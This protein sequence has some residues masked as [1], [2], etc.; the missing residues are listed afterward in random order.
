MGQEYEIRA[1]APATFMLMGEHAVLHGHPALTCAAD[2]RIQVRLT[3]HGAPMLRVHSSIAEYEANLD[4]LGDHPK[5]RFV[6]QAVRAMRDRLPS[7]FSLDITSDF[8]DQVGLGSSA[9]VTV[10]TAAALRFW[11]EGAAGPR[12]VF[13]DALD[14]VLK[15][16]GR[17]SGADIAASAF[18][19][20]VVYRQSPRA[21]ETLETLP[22][23]GLYYCGYKTP[24]PE[25]LQRVNAESLSLPELYPELYGLMGKTAS[26]AVQAAKEGDWERLGRLMNVYQGLMDALGVNDAALSDIV[27]RLRQQPGVLGAKISGSG[28]GDC[29][30]ALGESA[31]EA[32]PYEGI[33]VNVCPR[34]LEVEH[35]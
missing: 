16:Q 21:I 2:R 29:V 24:T 17:G 27:Y 4:S 34:G 7:G 28:L 5:L 9:A 32:L 35:G 19:G 10:A 8:S 26:Q 14:A 30:V 20:M 1:S 3:P 22:R 18:G 11:V 31:G 12:E 33:P 13:E 15:V 23:V 25:V 6:L